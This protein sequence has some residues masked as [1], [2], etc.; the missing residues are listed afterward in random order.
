LPAAAAGQRYLFV[1]DTGAADY[2]SGATAWAGTDGSI[3]SARAN[4]IVQYD[5]VRWNISFDSSN[6]SDVQYV[7]NLTTGIQYRWA[8]N[9]WLKSYEGLYPEGEWSLVL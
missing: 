4:D 7:T 1:G 2:N 5:G 8:D 6:Q 9:V 3:L